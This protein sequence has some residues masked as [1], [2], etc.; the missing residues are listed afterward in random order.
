[1]R[2]PQQ[3]IPQRRRIF[4]GC[5]GESE[6]SYGVLLGRLVEVRHGRI[7][8]DT[9]LLRPG[10]GDPL[11]LMERAVLMGRRVSRRGNYSAKV[12]LGVGKRGLHIDDGPNEH[13]YLA[14]H[15]KA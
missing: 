2:R 9:V 11:A 12:I 7:H 1:M 14:D 10:G 6:R 15:Y 5:E 13:V 4:L 3:R 8:L